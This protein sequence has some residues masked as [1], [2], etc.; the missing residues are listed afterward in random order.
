MSCLQTFMYTYNM[1]K[2]NGVC[3]GQT[4]KAKILNIIQ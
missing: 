3:R 4:V 1:I 2:I